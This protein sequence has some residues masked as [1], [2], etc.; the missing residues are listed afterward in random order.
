MK[1][2]EVIEG[3]EEFAFG[4]GP[5]GALLVHGYT[6]SPQGMRG[7]GE[8]LAER[9][10]A[11]VGPRLPGHGTTWQDLDTKTRD[12]WR[13]TV[14]EGYEQLAAGRDEIFIVA[15][16]FGAA[17]SLDFIAHNP[18]KVKGLVTL[19]GMVDTND[20]RRHFAPVI[21]RLTRSVAG[22]AND[23]ADPEGH[24]IAYDRLPTRSTHEML[25]VLT[26][27]KEVL[28]QVDC[29][30]LVMHGRNDHTVK[31]YNA[32]MIIEKVSSSDKELV[33]CENSFHVITLDKD[34][35][36]V[37]RRTHEFIKERSTHAV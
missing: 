10:I 16:S 22:V 12:E 17:L 4:D 6:G 7:L 5:T 33:W 23:I 13:R 26:E 34:R 28:P 29:S 36:E 1:E 30:L 9:G 14:T 32:E 8:Y 37:F 25:K 21:K 31:P 11:V 27:V 18:G 24:E 19:A 2:P 3:A 15:L 20:P 35:D